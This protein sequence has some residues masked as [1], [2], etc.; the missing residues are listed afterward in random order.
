MIDLQSLLTQVAPGAIILGGIDTKKYKA[1][2][3]VSG[4]KSVNPSPV[5]NIS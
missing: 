5:K 4:S 2:T 3:T 1:L